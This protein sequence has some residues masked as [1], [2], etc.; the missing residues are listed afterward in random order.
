MDIKFQITITIFNY[1]NIRKEHKHLS[2]SK[3]EKVVC[4]SITIYIT[5]HLTSNI[6]AE[7]CNI[8]STCLILI[9]IIKTAGET[10]SNTMYIDR[11]TPKNQLLGRT[12]LT[13]DRDSTYADKPLPTKIQK[14]N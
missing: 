4:Y 14:L 13:E 7:Y 8:I 10:E 5:T 9:V 3:H 6:N 12:M 1:K 2:T 11:A